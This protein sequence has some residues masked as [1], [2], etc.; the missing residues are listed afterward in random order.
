[1]TEFLP[2]VSVVIPTFQYGSTVCR[3]IESVKEQTL[4]NLSCIV[5]DDGSTDDTE[6]IVLDCIKDDKRFRYI[7]TTNR[8]VAWAR[9]TGFQASRGKYF[10]TLDADDKIE[11]AFLER[12]VEVLERN[13]SIG[14][15]YTGLRWVAPGSITRR[16]DWPGEFDY[17]KQLAGEN[18]CPTCNV[19]RREVWER[20]G[21]QRQ[22]YGILGCGTE[23][24]NMWLR[25]GSIGF[26]IVRATDEPLFVYSLG[27]G[28]TSRP[29]FKPVDY[30][31][32]HPWVY[33][34]HHP[35]ASIAKPE[36]YSH[37][38]RQYDSPV[39]SVIIPVGPGHEETII[40]ALD[41]LEAQTFR[42][43]E[44]I[45]VNDTGK[46]LD[47]WLT[48]YPYARQVRASDE[49]RG[50]GHARNRGAEI[51]R[52]PFLFFLD[53]DDILKPDC[54]SSVLQAWNESQSIVY[55]D[56]EAHAE[57]ISGALANR[58][59]QEGRLLHRDDTGY[60]VWN[61]RALDYDWERAHRQPENPPYIWNLISSLVPRAWHEEI[62]GFDEFMPSWE[63]WDYWVR[64][65]MSGKPFVRIPEPLVVYLYY[66]GSRRLKGEEI[67]G[68]LLHYLEQ[69][70]KEIEKMACPG[71]GSRQ[72]TYSPTTY[73]PTKP[74]PQSSPSDEEFIK[75]R[76][77]S[78]NRGWHGFIG[79]HRFEYPFQGMNMVRY[80]D[81]FAIDYG[82]ICGGDTI[83]AHREDIAA[84]RWLEP[85]EQ[86]AGRTER[87]AVPREP[88]AATP[89][90]EMLEILTAP[91]EMLEPEE[92]PEEI[93]GSAPL[94]KP[95]KLSYSNTD[96]R[97]LPIPAR[98]LGEL[99][100][101]GYA[102]IGDI[103]QMTAE[104]L[105]HYHGIGHNRAEAI[106]AGIQVLK[107]G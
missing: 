67:G 62:G 14:I 99:K 2:L 25:V 20:L 107:G 87:V 74:S 75:C 56:Y 26:D 98:T 34:G 27:T 36:L 17:Q 54:L 31:S 77:A 37:P 90:P 9:W 47:E 49:P 94:D 48:A 81:G 66:T 61:G 76:Y 3:A 28:I 70:Y 78:P 45:V 11:P 42:E 106:L 65:A 21:G 60:T 18:M 41:S 92:T 79:P 86:Y 32:W 100:R 103:E 72:T 101:D 6:K 59:H 96:M 38:V 5:V 19:A 63:D 44:A 29:D 80:D 10:C 85:I 91:P 51:A 39:V 22:R 12:C 73:S 102:T 82:Q 83:T 40:E 46:D 69:K 13:R 53:A 8:G 33:D 97:V 30:L 52:A 15:A 104:E 58:F 95:A 16:G 71:C 68:E 4:N 88:V 7:K 23:D 24:A 1:M 64:L 50:A 89:P 105:T 43:W 55:T 57:G 84:S 93:L 35:F